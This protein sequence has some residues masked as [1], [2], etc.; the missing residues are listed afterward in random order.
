VFWL[1]AITFLS[2]HTA[3]ADP[4]DDFRRGQA[5]YAAEKFDEAA[6]WFHK[7]ADQGLAEAQYVLGRMYRR[8]E[9]GPQGFTQAAIWF[10]KAAEQGLAIAEFTLGEEYRYGEGVTKD[11]KL[12][13]MWLQKAADQGVAGA[14]FYLGEAYRD[15]EGVAQDKVEAEKWFDI[16]T[17]GGDADAAEA[18]DELALGLTGDQIAE[19]RKRAHDWLNA[20]KTSNTPVN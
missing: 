11:P 19:A 15:G 18:R 17:A 10:G 9:I 7:A 8:G 1:I 13:L 5:A 12:A 16:A 20:L 3:W 14:Q 2:P 6:V 4:L